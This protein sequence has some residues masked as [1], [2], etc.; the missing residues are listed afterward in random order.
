MEASA[1]DTVQLASQCLQTCNAATDNAV[2]GFML[3]RRSFDGQIGLIRLD[4]GWNYL[5]AAPSC[6][7]P[8]ATNYLPTH[9]S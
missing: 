3:V 4:A 2:D 7:L 1:L 8:E 9:A 5:A 6:T